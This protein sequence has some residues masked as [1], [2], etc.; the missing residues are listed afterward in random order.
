MWTLCIIVLPFLLT[1]FCDGQQVGR[2]GSAHEARYISLDPPMP[3]SGR[4]WGVVG[5][6]EWAA[7][8]LKA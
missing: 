7:R 4:T 8:V 2:K 1:A 5:Q 3:D 6:L